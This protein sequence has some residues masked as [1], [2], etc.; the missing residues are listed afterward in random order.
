MAHGNAGRPFMPIMPI[1]C[2]LIS[3]SRTKKKYTG[4][5]VLTI[6]IIPVT[7]TRALPLTVFFETLDPKP[8]LTIKFC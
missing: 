6:R 8:K 1:R 5:S 7:V 3:P 4:S 2:T